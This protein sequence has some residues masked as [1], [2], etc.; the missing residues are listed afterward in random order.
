MNNTCIFCKIVKGEIPSTKVYEDEAVLAFMDIA[1]IIKGHTLVIPKEHWD[2]IFSTPASMLARVA[3][4]AQKIA[5]AQMNGL[6]ADG[7][8]IVQA[9]RKAAGQIVPHL[10][11]HV[12]PRFVTDGHHW[13]WAAKKYENIEEMTRFAESIRSGL[14]RD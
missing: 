12:I 8:N 7:V 1:P 13:N 6:K 11:V 3:A 2:D 4:V 10:H 5:L 9:N 14:P